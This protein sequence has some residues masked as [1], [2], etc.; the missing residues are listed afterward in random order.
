MLDFAEWRR[1][2]H[3]RRNKLEEIEDQTKYRKIK[4]R[5]PTAPEAGCLLRDP[6]EIFAK[7]KELTELEY[8]RA[9]IVD[10]LKYLEN[11]GDYPPDAPEK[12]N[13]KSVLE[14]SCKR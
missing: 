10:E 14:E 2:V 12:Y 9:R 5:G 11:T 4:L 1:A 8:R 6:V 13:A 7:D 3:D